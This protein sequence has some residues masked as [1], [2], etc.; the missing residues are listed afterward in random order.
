MLEGEHSAILLTFVELPFII[1]IFV[2]SGLSGRFTQVLLYEHDIDMERH[3]NGV[4]QVGRW[5]PAFTCFW[6]FIYTWFKHILF[7]LFYTISIAQII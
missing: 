2:L 5:W 6:M 4:S 7:I 3:I 1:K